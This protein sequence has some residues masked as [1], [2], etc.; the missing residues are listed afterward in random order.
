MPFAAVMSSH[1]GMMIFLN[2]SF[3][4]AKTVPDVTE[5]SA[6]HSGSEQRK[7]RRLTL[8]GSRQP[9]RGQ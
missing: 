3:R 1:T 7:R 5:N 8:Y 2:D 9:Q 4:F 6:R